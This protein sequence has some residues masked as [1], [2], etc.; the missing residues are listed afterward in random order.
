MPHEQNELDEVEQNEIGGTT[1]LDELAYILRSR[2]HTLG[3]F[4]TIDMLA[5][6][7]DRQ[8]RSQYRAKYTP[9]R[10]PSPRRLHEKNDRRGWPAD[11][12]ESRQ[13]GLNSESRIPKLVPLDPRL[14]KP[15]LSS[16]ESSRT[17]PSVYGLFRW[18]KMH[19]F[20]KH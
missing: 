19:G 8:T 15:R 5:S 16:S 18:I 6:T 12:R 7:P 9:P 13:L 14:S 11:D 10:S 4:C 2:R 3:H 1:F 17:R 20:N